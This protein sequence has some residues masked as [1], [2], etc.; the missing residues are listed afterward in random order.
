[1]PARLEIVA[2]ATGK[3]ASWVLGEK[4]DPP[5]SSSPGL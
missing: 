4:Q 5:A 3:Q 1:M 2:A